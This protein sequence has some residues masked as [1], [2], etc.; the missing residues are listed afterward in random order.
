MRFEGPGIPRD[1]RARP[2]ARGAHHRDRRRGDVLPRHLNKHIDAL[3]QGYRTDADAGGR[4]GRQPRDAARHGGRRATARSTSRPSA[5]ARSASSRPRAL[6]SDTLHARRRRPHRG[7]RRRPD[8][9]RARRGARP[10]L[11]ADALRQRGE[12]DR[13]RQRRPRSPSIRCTTPSRARCVAGRPFLYDARFTSS[14]GEASCASCHVFGDF[15]SLGLG[16]RQPRR[17]RA[18]QPQPDRRDRRRPAVPSDEGADDDADAARHGEPRADAL[19]RRP[20]RRQ[21]PRRPAG[22]RRAARLRGVQRRLRRPARTR[23][24]PDRRTP[25]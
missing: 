21:R 12:G 4:Q 9:P 20:H 16:S 5:R 6:E 8:R 15:D 25:T 19:A 10:P 23:R 11:R 14:N 17:R 7:Q 24:G 1:H 13:H 18:R 2:P 3:P 22:P